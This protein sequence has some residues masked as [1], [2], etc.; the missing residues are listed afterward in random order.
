MIAL[1]A[2]GAGY[3]HRIALDAQRAAHHAD[4]L[5]LNKLVSRRAE[6]HLLIA[7]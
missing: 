5:G 4:I 7:G 2:L 6:Q 1:A 3:H